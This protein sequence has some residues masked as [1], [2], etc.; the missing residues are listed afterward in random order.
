M[1]VGI[2]FCHLSTGWWRNDWN[3]LISISLVAVSCFISIS[4]NL[5]V[6]ICISW[7]CYLCYSLFIYSFVCLLIFNLNRPNPIC[8]HFWNKIKNKQKTHVIV[9]IYETQSNKQI[10]TFGSILSLDLIQNN[11]CQPQTTKVNCCRIIG[12]INNT[13]KSFFFR[14]IDYFGEKTYASVHAHYLVIHFKHCLCKQTQ[15]IFLRVGWGGAGLNTIPI[16]SQTYCMDFPTSCGCICRFMILYAYNS[17]K[18]FHLYQNL[19][20]PT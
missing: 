5:L 3:I 6:F 16:P 7:L 11:C 4:S 15:F 9:K 8:I 14:R 2:N 18:R 17:L 19:E 20:I 12:W 1:C 13:E 10:V